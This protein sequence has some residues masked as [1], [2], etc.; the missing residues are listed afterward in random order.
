MTTILLEDCFNSPLYDFYLK[1]LE[2]S[3]SRYPK[4]PRPK[5]LTFDYDNAEPPPPSQMVFGPL[6]KKPAKNQTPPPPPRP[7]QYPGPTEES[8]RAWRDSL[9]TRQKRQGGRR[10]V[11]NAA[12]REALLKR[13][14]SGATENQADTKGCPAA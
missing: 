6:P 4:Y 11:N 7:P 2:D 9:R 14:R 10:P 12:D 3:A 5:R 8:E 13:L 1:Y